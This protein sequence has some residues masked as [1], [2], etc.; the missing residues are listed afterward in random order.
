[1]HN[2]QMCDSHSHSLSVWCK[3]TTYAHHWH[4]LRAH[5]IQTYWNN[6]CTWRQQQHSAEGTLHF[7]DVYICSW[8]VFNVFMSECKL[9]W[10]ISVKFVIK[11]QHMK[12]FELNQK[13]LDYVT[14][15]QINFFLPLYVW[16]SCFFH[17]WFE[18][19]LLSDT[20]MICE[21]C[22]Q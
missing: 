22:R 5:T 6:T 20:N 7:L 3:P 21:D 11:K 17:N 10:R 15:L 18:W 12:M 19:N 4:T 1:M 2:T 14:I 9:Q 13:W 16:I 8:F